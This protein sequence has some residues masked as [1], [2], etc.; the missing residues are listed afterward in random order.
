VLDDN[1]Q[2]NEDFFK[3]IDKKELIQIQYVKL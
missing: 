1:L 3:P 2:I